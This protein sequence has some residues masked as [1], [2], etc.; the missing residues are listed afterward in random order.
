MSVT[1]AVTT[2]PC[3]QLVAVMAP[4][5]S[6]WAM[7]QPPKMS[8]DGL[9]SAGI[10]RV[11]AASSPRGLAGG[12]EGGTDLGDRSVKGAWVSIVCLLG[13]R[14]VLPIGDSITHSHAAMQHE[15]QRRLGPPTLGVL[16]RR[17]CCSVPPTVV[18]AIRHLNGRG[19]APDAPQSLDRE[20]SDLPHARRGGGGLRHLPARHRGAG[21]QLEPRRAA[22]QGLRR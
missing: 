18:G 14:R 22:P 17:R 15:K 9:M 5:A 11:R 20:R 21:P 2:R 4:A 19:R 12:T 3:A 1:A 13:W 7:I 6:I 16:T 8:P 10:A